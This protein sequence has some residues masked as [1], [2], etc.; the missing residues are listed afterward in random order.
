[1]ADA[2]D[3][4]GNVSGTGA[5]SRLMSQ[6]MLDMMMQAMQGAGFTPSADTTNAWQALRQQLNN[7][8]Q[9]GAR[10][11]GGEADPFGGG[12]VGSASGPQQQQG[13]MQHM[14]G[15]LESLVQ[16]LQLLTQ[17]LQPQGQ[18]S[19]GGST[20]PAAGPVAKGLGS[21]SGA[22]L[23]PPEA[24]PAAQG[25]AAHPW[26]AGS[27]WST[28]G[29]PEVP[30]APAPAPAAGAPAPAAS[31]GGRQGG[32]TP[33]SKEAVSGRLSE[34]D[35]KKMA[36]DVA[37]QLSKDFGLTREQAAGVVG[38][39]YHESAGMNSNVNEFGSDPSHPTFGSPN[40]SQFGYGWA[41]WTGDRK[42]A[43]LNFAKEQGLDPS[44][45]AANYA[46]LKHE[47][48]TSEAGTLD[49]L[50]QA[51]SPEEAAVVFRKVF[52]RAANPVDESRIAAANMIYGQMG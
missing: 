50:K 29:Q 14:Q 25:Q 9:A 46:M 22:P 35:G 17:M 39:L 45:P 2:L 36:L 38:N 37:E 42:T 28:N 23:S 10:Q 44:S 21:P 52:E 20:A 47:L 48:E 6:L 15:L 18:P 41:Q 11:L 33:F 34:G 31:G 7:N 8:L 3:A 43:F 24:G 5:T 16:L 49:A 1:M 26:G 19:P 40:G 30:G 12:G 32:L 27:P 13:P 4:V 51:R